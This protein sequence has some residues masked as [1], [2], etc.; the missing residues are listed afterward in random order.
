MVTQKLMV[1]RVSDWWK[2]EVR[3]K[4]E[5]RCSMMEL[6]DQCVEGVTGEQERLRLCARNWE[7][8]KIV[9]PFPTSVKWSTSCC[10]SSSSLSTKASDCDAKVLSSYLL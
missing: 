9:R 4:G 8:L 3:E 2:A 1:E 6:G 10:M 7:S 5:W